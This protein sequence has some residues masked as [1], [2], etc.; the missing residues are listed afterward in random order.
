[1]KNTI[2]WLK[3]RIFGILLCLIFIFTVIFIRA[4]QLQVI[5]RDKLKAIAD[6][7][8]L[9]TMDI[10]PK[11]GTIYER[12]MHELA[13]SAVVY[14]VYAH[15]AKIE[16]ERKTVRMLAAAIP[17]MDRD[18]IESRLASKKS[19]VWIKRQMNFEENERV[20]KLNI[21]GIGLVK[22]GKRFYPT[23]Q[24][25]SHLIG[26]VGVDSMGL[27][28]IELGYDKHMTGT[29]VR[30]I[31][32]RDARGNE[33]LL[34]GIDNDRTKGMNLVLTIDRTIQYITEK[35]LFKAVSTSRAKG[36]IAIA[37][38]P[39]TGEILAMANT[40]HFNPDNILEY[41]SSTV[42]RNK[43]VTDAFE[44]GSTFK[45][46]IIAAALE[47]NAAKPDDLFFCEEGSYKVADRI[48]HDVKKFGWLSLTQIIKYS[49]NIGAVKIGER[50]GKERLYRYV[51][52]FG[53]G[54]KTGIG[55]PGEGTGSVTDLKRWSKITASNISF[56][57]GLS[58]TGIQLLSAFSA[59]A[60]HGYLM[61]PYVVKEIVNEKGEV[62]EQFRPTVVRRVISEETAKKVINILKEVT[63]KEGTGVMAALDGFEVAGKT[64][65]AQKPDLSNGGYMEDKY[66]SSFI[67]FVPADN[68]ELAILIVIDEPSG[69]FYGG[70][71][72]APV[73]KEIAGQSLSYLRISPEGSRGN[74]LPI[75][76]TRQNPD[77]MEDENNPPS[78]PFEKGGMGGFS[79]EGR[80]D[81]P[82]DLSYK[83]RMPDLRGKTIRS[84]LRV[85]REI[86]IELRISGSGKAV[87]Q[88][89]LPGE[90][91]SQEI[92]A[93]V[94]FR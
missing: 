20:R 3:F 68:P 44:P 90:R 56:G 33:I 67:G 86:P 51:R 37:M 9:K 85:L 34:G 78:P 75:S 72:A 13:V 24:I 83:S 29:P 18:E 48:I 14:S 71:I 16:N 81:M 49:S 46:F 12:G 7:E 38:A 88:K 36:G 23:P 92:V 84:V 41:E 50:T 62:V 31:G 2:P 65:T 47:E 76:I 93:E 60:N 15:P 27:E 59:I 61:K 66:I 53:F 32:E 26:F 58:V 40:P 43:A 8:Y 39:Q 17:S 45:P 80:E 6:R 73:F 94:R 4:F 35:E 70:Q 87:S 69:E 91:I 54:A 77:P 42:W 21:S 30:F 25:A 55:L 22:E 10:I 63:K 1:M 89:P 57:Q 82:R 79:D 74:T 52:D 11:R 19:F 5:D 64:G 28:G